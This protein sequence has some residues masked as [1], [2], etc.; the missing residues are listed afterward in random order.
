VAA[1][2][3][4]F[5]ELCTTKSACRSPTASF[6]SFTPFAQS[7][8]S[9]LLTCS[10]PTTCPLDPIP[11]NLFQSIAP[12]VSATVTHVVNASLTSGTFPTTFKQAQVTPLLKKPSLPPTHVE[13]Y[14]LVSLLP[15]LSKTIERAVLSKT[16]ERAIFKQ[17]T[18]Y[19]SH[20]NLLDPNQSGFKSGHSTETALLAV[21]EALKEARA[22]AKSSVL[23]L[24]DLSAAFDTVNHSM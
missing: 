18:D 2:S 16:I 11:T 9:K 19:L 24:L 21:T 5:T 6:S 22:I 23:I 1:I 20:N 13:N 7:S 8:V 14:R 17:V 10:R 12:T 4:Q 3:K 15:F